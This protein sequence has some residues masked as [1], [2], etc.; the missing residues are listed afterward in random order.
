MRLRRASEVVEMMLLWKEQFLSSW[1]FLV[2]E[3]GTT[4]EN[5]EAKSAI[6][7]LKFLVKQTAEASNG[8]SYGG[9]LLPIATSEAGTPTMVAV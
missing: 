2:V 3:S 8:R 9:Y 7:L 4:A 1:V 5:T 6:K